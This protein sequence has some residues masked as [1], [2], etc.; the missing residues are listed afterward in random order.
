MLIYLLFEPLKIKQQE[1]KDLPLLVIGDFVMYELQNTGLGT[2]M[3]GTEALRYTDRYLVT[4]V[5]F[6]DNSKE[7][8]SNM[9]ANNG[10][11]K[12]NIV[13]LSGDVV[14]TREDGLTFKSDTLHYNTMSAIAHTKDNYLAYR[15]ENSMKG[16]S[17]VYNSIANTMKSKKVTVKYQF[18]ESKI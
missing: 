10:I 12:N 11:Y 3:S 13:V 8:I 2:I 14:Y 7:Y 15:N 1:F 9:E 6:T 17:F 18:K 4:N 5:N 16:S